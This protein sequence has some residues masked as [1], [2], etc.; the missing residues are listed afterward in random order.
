MA[1]DADTLA[2]SAA[3]AGDAGTA[4][5]VPDD[6]PPQPDSAASARTGSASAGRQT[7]RVR[8][9]APPLPT[10]LFILAANAS[11]RS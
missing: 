10:L 11:R 8:T 9:L 3:A 6:P 1:S 2:D 4:E 7:I 5:A